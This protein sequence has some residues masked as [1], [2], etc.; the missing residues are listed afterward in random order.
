MN[1][2]LFAPVEAGHWNQH[3]LWD[4]TYD[5]DD[6]LDIHEM[7]SVSN[8]NKMRSYDAAKKEV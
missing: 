1:A 4:G 2:F 8:E 7:M 3:E 5:L 6:L